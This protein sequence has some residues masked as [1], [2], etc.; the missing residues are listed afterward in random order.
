M[1]TLFVSLG[2]QE[3]I[4]D[5]LR[6]LG[7]VIYWDWSGYHL[8]SKFHNTICSLVDTHKPDLIFLQIQSPGVI[9]TQTAHY[10]SKIATV[11]NWTGDVRAPLPKWFIEI[12][13]NIKLTLFSNMTDVEEARSKGINADY[14]QIG[15][16]TKIFNNKVKPNKNAP[17]IVFMGNNCGGFPLSSYRVEMV[18]RLQERYGEKFKVF[19]TNWAGNHAITSQQEEAAMYRGCKVAINLSH[20]DYKRYSSDRIFRLM[21]AGAFCLSHRYQEIE[22]DFEAGIHLDVWDSIEQLMEKID[23]YLE[24][25]GLRK[26]IAKA[27][28]QYVHESHTWENRIA[29]LKQMID[30]K[31]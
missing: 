16:P 12:G 27:G 9:S 1:K 15:F 25:E 5:A 29:Q 8:P 2:K 4:R 28:Y 30:A 31:A 21:G 7:D 14:L 26:A 20:F 18:R 22:R 6:S 11:V 24:H 17:E 10:I 13:H 3:D 23:Y 19:G